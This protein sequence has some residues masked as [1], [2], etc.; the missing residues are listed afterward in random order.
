MKCYYCGKGMESGRDFIP[1]E[2][3]GTK[4]RKWSCVDC[5][6]PHEKELVKNQLG[7]DGLKIS[8]I[9]SPNFLRS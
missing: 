2:P 1:I 6:K 4:N 3:A 7:E 5:A 8:R 9:F